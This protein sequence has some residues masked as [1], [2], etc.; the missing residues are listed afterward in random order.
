MEFFSFQSYNECFISDVGQILFSLAHSFAVHHEK[1]FVLAFFKVSVDHDVFDNLESGK[2]RFLFWKKVWKK[3]WILD[4]KS[5]LTQQ[6]VILTSEYLFPSL[7]GFSPFSYSFI[8][9]KRCTKKNCNK[10]WHK[11]IW[12]VWTYAV[13]DMVSCQPKSYP[14]QTEHVLYVM[15]EFPNN[16][17]V[18]LFTCMFNSCLVNIL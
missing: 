9:A 2:S 11:H 10:E 16:P 15:L 4:L 17:S 3:S 7:V 8:L 13:F 1:R 6:I 12:Y 5:L 14:V 18:V